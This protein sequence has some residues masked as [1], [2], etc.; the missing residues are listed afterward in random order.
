MSNGACGGRAPD[1]GGSPD[2]RGHASSCVDGDHD[3]YR[4]RGSPS[5]DMYHGHHVI[6]AIVRDVDPGGGWPT[7]TKINYVE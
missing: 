7:L 4:R 6:Q 1:G 2:R 3:I 5:L